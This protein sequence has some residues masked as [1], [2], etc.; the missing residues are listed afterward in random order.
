MSAFDIPAGLKLGVWGEKQKSKALGF[1]LK[2]GDLGKALADL[3]A[4]NAAVRDELLEAAPSSAA[5]AEAAIK[6]LDGAV[7]AELKNLRGGISAVQ[8]AE[9]AFVADAKKH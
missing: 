8:Q 1:K 3:V 2:P 7:K 5:E 9:D 4:L 6:K